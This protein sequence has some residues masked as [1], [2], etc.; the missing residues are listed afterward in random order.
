[1]SAAWAPEEPD[2]SERPID[3]DSLGD[4]KCRCD[5]C[6]AVGCAKSVRIG[7]TRNELCAACFAALQS[8]VK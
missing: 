7:W 1:M 6:G 4:N 8:A 2:P 3:I 5:V